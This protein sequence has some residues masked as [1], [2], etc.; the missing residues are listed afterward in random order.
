MA[1]LEGTKLHNMA[2]DPLKRLPV[3]PCVQF[4]VLIIVVVMQLLVHFF[5]CFK[6]I[7]QRRNDVS[8]EENR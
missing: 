6:P 5:F 3:R 1:Q 2:K 7:V 4:S 8:E